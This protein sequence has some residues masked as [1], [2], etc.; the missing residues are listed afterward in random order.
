MITKV[1]FQ[2]C[3]ECKDGLEKAT[4]AGRCLYHYR[5][6][7]K[8]QQKQIRLKLKLAL[9]AIPKP[10]IIKKIGTIKIIGMWYKYFMVNAKKECENCES[11]LSNYNET[12]WFDSQFHILDENEYPSVAGNLNNHIVLGTNCCGSQLGLY[13][14]NFINMKCSGIINIRIKKLIPFLSPE[15]LNK[16]KDAYK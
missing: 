8:E 14:G 16:L 15:E 3:P 9:P 1:R 6:W 12:D 5:K 4:I 10:K 11:N 2:T 13:E 7:R